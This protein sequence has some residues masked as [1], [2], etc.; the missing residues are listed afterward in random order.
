MTS[1]IAAFEDDRAA[2][3]PASGDIVSHDPTRSRARRGTDSSTQPLDSAL[4]GVDLAVIV[5]GHHRVDHGLPSSTRRRL[6]A[7]PRSTTRPP[8]R[9]AALS[10]CT[11]PGAAQRP[12]PERAAPAPTPTPA[13]P[14]PHRAIHRS[15]PTRQVRDALPAPPLPRRAPPPPAH[16]R[17]RR[18]HRHPRRHRLQR[19]ERQ[20][21]VVCATAR[22][23]PPPGGEA[24]RGRATE[25]AYP[26]HIHLRGGAAR[27]APA[28]PPPPPA[29]TPPAGTPPPRRRSPSPP[30]PAPRTARTRPTPHEDAEAI[31]R[32]TDGTTTYAV[33]HRRPQLPQPR[34][35]RR[36]GHHGTDPLTAATRGC[37][38]ASAAPYSTSRPPPATRRG[39]SGAHRAPS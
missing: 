7:R 18:H 9:A 1:P 33:A 12:P 4:G 10:A 8:R 13:H 20:D 14:L 34:E 39:S 26:P 11:R 36:A 27:R 6:P 38:S 35:R 24:R 31:D 16:R 37:H 3:A 5:T 19:R 17:A 28:H 21:L 23:R 15:E 30:P 2:A 22:W 32:C 25:K 29:A